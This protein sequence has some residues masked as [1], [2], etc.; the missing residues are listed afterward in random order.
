MVVRTG[1][2]IMRLHL[3]AL[4]VFINIFDCNYNNDFFI[5]SVH[6]VAIEFVQDFESSD[7]DDEEK[8]VEHK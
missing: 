2:L 8:N 5:E 6:S 3:I 4:K 7:D 1:K